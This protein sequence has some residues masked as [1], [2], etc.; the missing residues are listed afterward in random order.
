MNIPLKVLKPVTYN[1]ILIDIIS[2]V[3]V[4]WLIR[5]L[6]LFEFPEK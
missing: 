5:E 4:A 1:L 2:H 3:D 6:N